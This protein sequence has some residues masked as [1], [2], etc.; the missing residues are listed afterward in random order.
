MRPP[1]PPQPMGSLRPARHPAIRTSAIRRCPHSRS[2]TPRSPTA[3][4]RQRAGGS[5]A[6][7]PPHPGVAVGAPRRQ[8]PFRRDC[9]R[10]HHRAGRAHRIRQIHHR[11]ACL[12]AQAPAGALS[13]RASTPLTLR[14][15]G[16][17]EDRSDMRRSFP[18]ISFSPKPSLTTSLSG[19]ATSAPTPLPSTRSSGLRSSAAASQRTMRCCAAPVRPVRWPAT[20]RGARGRARHGPAR[21]HPR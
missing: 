4:P 8:R 2:T 14:T 12:R 15:A 1:A 21:A 7:A 16:T 13:S 11:R 20:A 5:S 10:S 19:R 17:C 18:S 6:G 9:L 3:M